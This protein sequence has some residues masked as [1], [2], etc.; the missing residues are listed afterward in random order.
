MRE[1][2]QRIEAAG[3]WDLFVSICRRHKLAPG[4][5]LAADCTYRTECARLD[6][7]IALRHDYRCSDNEIAM[8]S[9]RHRKTVARLLNCGE[10]V[11]SGNRFTE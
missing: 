1:L 11:D 9:G 6:W 4:S 3:K 7:M 5:V 2:R 10:H 8:L